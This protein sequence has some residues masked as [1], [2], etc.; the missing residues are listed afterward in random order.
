MFALNPGSTAIR[1]CF[2]GENGGKKEEER[3]SGTPVVS[4][5]Q[6]STSLHSRLPLARLFVAL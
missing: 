4:F 3:I 1:C 6:S 2:N 5:T